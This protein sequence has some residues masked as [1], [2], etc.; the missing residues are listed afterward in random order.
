[1]PLMDRSNFSP[2]A[3]SKS[4]VTIKMPSFTVHGTLVIFGDEQVIYLS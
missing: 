3:S 1:M 4:K 2:G